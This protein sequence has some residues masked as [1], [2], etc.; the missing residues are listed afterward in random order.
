VKRSAALA[1]LLGLAA[2]GAE[3]QVRAPSRPMRVVS[4]DYCADQYVLELL[5]R[6][7][8]LAVSP[9]A[10]K[11]ESYKRASAAGVRQVAARAE[12]VLVLRPD[13]VV[14]SYG[15]GPDAARFFAEADVPVLQIGYAGDLSGVR[16][17][18]LEV[19][20]GLGERRRGEAMVEE[21]DRRLAQLPGRRLNAEALYMT[22]A[23]VT[24]GPDTLVNEL[25]KAAGFVNFQRQAGW[26]PLPLERLAYERP[27]L[28][29]AASFGRGAQDGWTAA[30]HP[31]AQAQLRERPVVRLQ[32]AWVACG[33]WFVLNAVEAMA[34][35]RR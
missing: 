5:P 25:M 16:R 24:A 31:V 27:D 20:S 35:A 33:G 32:G 26:Q 19:A 15:G 22:E 34:G 17:T 1:V 12:D 29:A 9:D 3:Q 30:R 8:I 23:G 18:L 6:E 21:M 13:L 28:V 4:L 2:C 7:R 10:T 11:P 14:R